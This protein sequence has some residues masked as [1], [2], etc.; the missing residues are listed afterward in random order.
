MYNIEPTKFPY[1]KD[2]SVYLDSDYGPYFGRDLYLESNFTSNKSCKAYFPNCY[3]DILNKGKSIFTG[4][5]NNEYF[6]LKELEV[7]ELL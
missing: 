4:N 2:R 3:F 6:T 7:F 5:N 1:I